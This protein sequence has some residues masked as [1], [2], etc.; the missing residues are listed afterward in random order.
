MAN[1]NDQSM[2]ESRNKRMFAGML[3]HLNSG[4]NISSG[5]NRN[6]TRNTEESNLITETKSRPE[7]R[8]QRNNRQP[9]GGKNDFSVN[10]EHKHVPSRR[11]QKI[12]DVEPDEELLDLDDIISQISDLNL[13]CD[14]SAAQIKRN[15]LKS[16]ELTETMDEEEWEKLCDCLINTA[17]DQGEHDFVVDLF[18]SLLKNDTFCDMMSSELMNISANHIMNNGEKN[19]PSFLSSIMCAHWPRQFSKAIDTVN[20]ILYSTACII[21]GWIKV[22][23]DDNKIFYTYE[24]PKPLPPSTEEESSSTVLSAPE[25]PEE[26]EPEDPE[27]VNRCALAVCELCETAQRQLWMQWPTIC[28]EIYMAVKPAITHNAN[29]TGETKVRLLNVCLMLNNWTRSKSTTVKCS[30]T[31]TV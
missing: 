20:L 17:L 16:K 2:A 10:T 28:D 24:K 8:S 29:L 4:K 22:L 11:T 30:Q 6:S 1:G 12:E 7:T 9:R 5:G 25:H 14:R 19:V 18:I 26:I 13:R 21:K 23:E 3:G 31:Q 15:I 27:I